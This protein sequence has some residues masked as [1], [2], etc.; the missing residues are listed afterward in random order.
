MERRVR[1]SALSLAR[2]PRATC[3][4]VLTRLKQSKRQRREP[5]GA[6]DAVPDRAR[7]WPKAPASPVRGAL[8]F[9]LAVGP[10]AEG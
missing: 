5:A 8:P 3:G 1:V 10:S 4:G 9:G 7:W 2:G 6:G